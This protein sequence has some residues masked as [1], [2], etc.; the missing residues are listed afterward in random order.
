MITSREDFLM[1]VLDCGLYDLKLIDDVNY[2][3]CDILEK[4]GD[5]SYQLNWL[6]RK[7]F[8]FGFGQINEALEL[9]KDY[10][11]QGEEER[12]L[13]ESEKMELERLRVLDPFEDFESYHN[14]IDTHVWCEK[15]GSTY[16]KYLQ[17]ALDEFADGT[18][19]EIT[20]ENEEE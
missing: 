20:I 4:A 5:T 19:F 12:N 16:K 14:F 6:M 13:L 1:Q 7:V 10:L 8:E 2:D 11:M 3:W 18:G 9:R 17:E 15:H